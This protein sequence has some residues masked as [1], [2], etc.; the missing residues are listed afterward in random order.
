MR[1]TSTLLLA[2]F[3]GLCTV[4]LI[5]AFAQSP[6]APGSG[7]G[8]LIDE[9]MAANLTCSACHA[10]NP[11]HNAPQ[12]ATCLG[13]HGGT[14]DKLAAMT[15][16]DQPNPH[17]SHQGTVPCSSC[18]HVH[19][20]SQTFCNSCHNF[21]MTPPSGRRRSSTG[22]SSDCVSSGASI[23]FRARSNRCR[24]HRRP[25]RTCHLKCWR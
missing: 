7:H 20:A 22:S 1:R 24:R 10:E 2:I 14:Y 16:S 25:V 4:I 9:H 5:H 3:V 21:D 12:T 19:V 17:D 6:S 18:H 8:F 13:C 11:P 15:A 23:S